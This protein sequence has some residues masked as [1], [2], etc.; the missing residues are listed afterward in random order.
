MPEKPL[1]IRSFEK[2]KL[3]PFIVETY[4][5]LKV[6]DTYKRVTSVSPGAYV[7]RDSGEMVQVYDVQ[8]GTCLIDNQ[9]FLKSFIYHSTSFLEEFASMPKHAQKV[10]LYVIK[11]MK[12]DD[13]VVYFS[14]KD[15]QAYAK[16]PSIQ[17]VYNGVAWLL[18]NSFIARTEVDFK[19]YLNPTK[20][21][22]GTR[23]RLINANPF[24][25]Q[26]Q[27]NVPGSEIL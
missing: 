3:N 22:N 26:P 24:P 14:P 6:K 17:S 15:C 11:M 2:H 4:A 7:D 12:K 16:Y 13:D 10:M 25:F 27:L 19:Y 1:T 8:K 20:V 21:F 5:H 9:P 23:T 18:A